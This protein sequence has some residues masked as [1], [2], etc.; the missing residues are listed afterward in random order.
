M[1]RKKIWVKTFLFFY[2]MLAIVVFFFLS[3]TDFNGDL[4]RLGKLGEYAFGWKKKKP[5]I[6]PELLKSSS[7]KDSDIVV[8]GDSFSEKFVWQTKLTEAGY[9]V[10]TIHWMD[11][12]NLLCSDFGK[13]LLD[14]QFKGNLVIIET[15]QR[16]ADDKISQSLSC[17]SGKVLL[18]HEHSQPPPLTRRKKVSFNFKEKIMTGIETLYNT[19]QA[20]SPPR[21]NSLQVFGPVL[22]KPL[23]KGCSW[24]S[25]RYCETGLFLSHD[26]DS[27]PL[28][29][30]IVEKIKKIN[31]SLHRFKVIWL[32][33][34]DKSSV[35]TERE[36]LGFWKDLEK[37]NLGPDL[38]SSFTKE[39]DNLVDLYLPND[40]HLSSAGSLF[41][42][43]LVK[44][45]IE[46]H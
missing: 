28:T 35:Y 46:T 3:L 16:M 9:K 5:K 32:V 31:L 17:S 33:V 15:V 13:I 25:N 8:I 41:M 27:S 29:S 14:N 22:L 18:D 1:K 2:F 23:H 6:D 44:Q 26:L 36:E 38:L 24:F 12:D 40:T 34:P 21:V 20:T 7:F 11:I 39:R 43:E 30:K 19:I 37:N 4:T 45:W 42:G 10:K